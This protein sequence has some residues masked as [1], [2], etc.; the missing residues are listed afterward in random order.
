MLELTNFGGWA[1][2]FENKIFAM[3][4]LCLVNRA[5]YNLDIKLN[6]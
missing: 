3:H 1:V 6:F 4:Y 2:H 5:K